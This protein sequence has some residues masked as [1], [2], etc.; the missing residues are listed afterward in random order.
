MPDDLE[1]LAGDPALLKKPEGLTVAAY[2]FPNYHASALHNKIYSQGWTE[3]N[4]IRSARPWFEGHQQPRTPL[5]GS[6]MRVSLLLGRHIT[7]FANKVA[8]MF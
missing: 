1:T 3:Y 2:A 8:L 7:S 4:L 5:L 6:L